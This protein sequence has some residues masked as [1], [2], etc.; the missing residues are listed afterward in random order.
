MIYFDIPAGLNG[1]NRAKIEVVVEEYLLKG[2]EGPL[3][4]LRALEEKY[5]DE[6]VQPDPNLPMFVDSDSDETFM[7]RF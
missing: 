6:Y 1:G 3:L 5:S 7:D 2:G 4:D